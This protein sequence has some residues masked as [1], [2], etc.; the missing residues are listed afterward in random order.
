MAT[1]HASWMGRAE[2][3]G[4]GPPRPGPRLGQRAARSSRAASWRRAAA[5]TSSR[6]PTTTRASCRLHPR[7]GRQL[8]ALRPLLLLHLAPPGP[9]ATTSGRPSPA[10]S[11]T[12]T[13]RLRHGRQPVGDDLRPRARPRPERPLLRLGPALLGRL[14]AARGALDQ[15]DRAL[16]PGLRGRHAPEHLDRRPAVQGRRRRR[17]PVGRRAPAR[18]RAPRPGL[19]GR[20]GQRVRALAQL[21]PRRPLHHLRRVGRLLRPRAPAAGGGR[22]HEPRPQQGLRPDGLPHPGR[23][24]VAL[25][26]PKKKSG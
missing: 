7:R 21:P 1:R 14:G 25:R 8:H 5:T 9:T 22:P 11:S 2:W 20:R 17:R 15:P 6:S 23:H 3:Q 18:R 12:T 24:G 26:A 16:L 13:R 4:C 19:H 10:G